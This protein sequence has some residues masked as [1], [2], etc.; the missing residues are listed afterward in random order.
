MPSVTEIVIRCEPI[1]L[2]SVGE[3]VN[4]VAPLESIDVLMFSE[5]DES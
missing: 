1:S 4:I 3:T 2:R 5:G